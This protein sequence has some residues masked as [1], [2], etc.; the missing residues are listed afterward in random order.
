MSVDIIKVW[1]LSFSNTWLLHVNK[2]LLYEQRSRVGGEGDLQAA[3]HGDIPTASSQLVP[4][5]A[6]RV[7]KL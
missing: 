4:L 6:F 5:N 1:I 3:E 2:L 7:C